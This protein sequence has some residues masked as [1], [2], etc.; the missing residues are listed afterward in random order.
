MYQMDVGCSLK[1]STV[2]TI[3]LWHHAHTYIT[4]DFI[5]LFSQIWQTVVIVEMV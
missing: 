2:S 4:Q 3:A 1:G 5:Q